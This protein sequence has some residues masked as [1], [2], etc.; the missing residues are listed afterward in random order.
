MNRRTPAGVLNSCDS[1][2]SSIKHAETRRFLC[3]REGILKLQNGILVIKR[4]KADVA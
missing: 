4:E 2:I 1:V 3:F